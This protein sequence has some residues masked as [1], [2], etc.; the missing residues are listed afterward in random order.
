MHLSSYCISRR[1]PPFLQE[2]VSRL[3][4]G[5]SSFLLGCVEGIPSYRLFR[6]DVRGLYKRAFVKIS[7]CYT[8]YQGMEQIEDGNASLG[9]CRDAICRYNVV[10]IVSPLGLTVIPIELN[11]YRP[12]ESTV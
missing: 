6:Q 11:Q 2:T 4:A 8:A 10:H 1:C 9:F 3:A 5:Q 7:L 12:G